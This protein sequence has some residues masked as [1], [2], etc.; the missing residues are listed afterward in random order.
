MSLVFLEM[1]KYKYKSANRKGE[2][3]TSSMQ[4]FKSEFSLEDDISKYI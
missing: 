4:K 2:A 1:C 3:D